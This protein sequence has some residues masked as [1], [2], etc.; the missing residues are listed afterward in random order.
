MKSKTGKHKLNKLFGASAYDAATDTNYEGA[1]SFVRGDEEAL[2]RVLTTGT[3]EHTFYATDVALAREALDLFRQ[4]AVDDPHFLA[5][6]ILY[7]R[8]E[9][10]MRIVPITALVVLSTAASE[11]AREMFRRVF[12]RVILTPGDLQDFL[13]L[14]R[15]KQLRGM[16]KAVTHAAQRWLATLSQYHAIKY[17]SAS[18]D[19]SL[20]DIYRLTRPRLTGA[21]NAIARYLV[22]GEVDPTLTQIAGYEQFK[23]EALE[24]KELHLAMTEREAGEAQQSLL[25]LIGEHRLPWEVVSGQVAGAAAEVW[26]AM[27]RQMPYLALLRNLNNAVKSGA[28]ERDGVLEYITDTLADPARVASGKIFPFQFYGALK[29]LKAEGEVEVALRAA[30]EQALDLS[31]VNMPALGRRVLIANDISG[32]MVAKPSPRGD[33]TM[34][35]IASIFAAAAFK[36][37]EEGTIVSFDT[38]AH[39]REVSRAGSLAGIAKAISAHDGGTSLAAPIEYACGTTKD[40]AHPYDVAIFLTDSESWYDHLKTNRGSLD[41]IR[42]YRARIN[43]DLRCFFIQLVPYRHAVVPQ[44]EPG[45]SY[46]YGWS[47]SILSFI[48]AELAGGHAQ[49]EHVRQ[50]SVL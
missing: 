38:Q 17:G 24:F 35:E 50:V 25:A 13:T 29:A 33:M 3:F 11:D 41:L 44:E 27:V 16:G 36:R 12:P 37:A 32:S 28:V 4:F 30:L 43:P 45:C 19:M 47:A 6:A 34:A 15:Q 1:P 8:N 10:L 49:V 31:F 9:G 23:R 21:A 5:Q 40:R 18:Q 42:E 46:I 39:R 22:K 7:A 14:C 20:R 26:A 2:V 48:A